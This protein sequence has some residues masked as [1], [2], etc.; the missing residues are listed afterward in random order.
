VADMSDQIE[1]KYI[2]LQYGGLA[3]IISSAWTIYLFSSHIVISNLGRLSMIL[4]PACLFGGVFISIILH[5]KKQNGLIQFKE[6]FKTGLLATAT[7]AMMM[8]IVTFVCQ[9][10]IYPEFSIDAIANAKA[11]GIAEKVDPKLMS[12]VLKKMEEDIKIGAQVTKTIFGGLLTGTL[13]SL[14]AAGL[15]RRQ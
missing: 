4:I 8:A 1:T 9:A 14:V 3:G 6:G 7:Y 13:V 12:D 2:G 5:R 10:I 11:H 15:M